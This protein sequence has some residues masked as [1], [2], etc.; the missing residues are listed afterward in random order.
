M[1][2]WPQQSGL[3]LLPRS[4][5]PGTV[6][7]HWNYVRNSRPSNGVFPLMLFRRW[8]PSAAAAMLALVLPL[9]VWGAPARPAAKRPAAKPAAK[10]APAGAAAQA[11]AIAQIE[12]LGGHVQEVAQN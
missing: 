4:A 9:A 1:R 3:G 12:K 10:A 2:E 11:A 7:P 6:P 8:F 5:L